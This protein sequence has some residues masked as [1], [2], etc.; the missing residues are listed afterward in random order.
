M[1][2][3]I[4]GSLMVHVITTQ[5]R[6]QPSLSPI[7]G[8]FYTGFID[9]SRDYNKAIIHLS[10]RVQLECICVY[11]STYVWPILLLLQ[12]YNNAHTLA[13]SVQIK[14]KLIQSAK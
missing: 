5:S 2:S 12:V 11:N 10:M 9:S 6:E 1:V 4:L 14:L 13:V 7:C 3:S 8:I